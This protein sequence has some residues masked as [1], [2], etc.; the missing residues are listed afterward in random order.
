MVK[1]LK[2][3]RWC[4]QHTQRGML[5]MER[6]RDHLSSLWPYH[7]TFSSG[8]VCMLCRNATDFS[9]GPQNTGILEWRP[10]FV[11]PQCFCDIF[12]N[13]LASVFASTQTWTAV[14]IFLVLHRPI[15]MIFFLI[16]V[17]CVC[18]ILRRGLEL[19]FRA[20]E[21]ALSPAGHFFRLQTFAAKRKLM[22]PLKSFCSSSLTYWLC[23]TW[24]LWFLKKQP[25]WIIAVFFFH[26]SKT[27]PGHSFQ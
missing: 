23:V 19:I 24:L 10:H 22:H 27:H 26:L 1:H 8:G 4:F 20:S 11:A 3:S 15:L 2:P 5:D 18:A 25:H 12:H 14:T 13:I 9:N 6:S 17:S 7:A 16:H 21:S